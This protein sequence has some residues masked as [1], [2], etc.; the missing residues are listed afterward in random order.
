MYVYSLK[1][2]HSML[3]HNKIQK[4]PKPWYTI[5]EP[6]FQ[7]FAKYQEIRYAELSCDNWR[8]GAITL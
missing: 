5:L 6:S 2:I 8:L 1:V 4:N 3:I 7:N